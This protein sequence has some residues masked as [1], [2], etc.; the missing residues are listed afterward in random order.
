MYSIKQCEMFWSFFYAKSSLHSESITT[1]GPCVG[2]AVV[3]GLVSG[4][5]SSS[6]PTPAIRNGA[7][8]LKK[9]GTTVR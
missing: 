8:K 9:R 7:A 4:V 6:C 3:A 1:P 5:L 2:Y